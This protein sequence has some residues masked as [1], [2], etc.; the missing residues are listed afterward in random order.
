[1][2]AISEARLQGVH[3][4]LVD[5][6]RSMAEILKLE[7]ITIRVV[8]G[9][10]TWAQQQALWLAGRDVNGNI[11]DHS[12]VVT[13]AKPGHSYHNYGLAVDVAPFD[14]SIPDWNPAHP[15]WKRIVAIG[16]SVGLTSGSEWRTFPDWPHFQMTGQL[17]VSPDDSV[18]AEFQTGGIQAVWTS[19]LLDS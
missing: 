3:P 16:E 18:R 13:N 10:R 12:K 19:T 14:A 5:R 9:L 17:P 2:D 15:A 6:V 1:M 7:N 8:Q 11:V 4:K